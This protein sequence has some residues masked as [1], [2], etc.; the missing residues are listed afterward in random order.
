MIEQISLLLAKPI[1][2][3]ILDKF[4]DGVGSKLGELAVEKFPEKVKQLGQLVWEKCL[5]GKTDTDKLLEG[6][7]NGSEE[8]QKK[9]EAHLSEILKSDLGFNQEVKQ[10]ATEIYQAIQEVD[11]H[12]VQQVF[13]GQGLQVNDPKAPVIQTGENAKFYF[14]VQSPD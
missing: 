2:K 3:I 6:A 8:E 9:L 12:N 13:G 14:G 11:A 7:T 4:Y 1:V 10:L 5:R